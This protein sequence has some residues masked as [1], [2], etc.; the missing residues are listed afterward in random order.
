MHL[1]F[2]GFLWG[3]LGL[4]IPVLIHLL[5]LR[6]PQRV[7][8][9]NTGFIRDIEF[10]TGRRRIQDWI[11]LGLRMMAVV[12]LVSAFCQPYIPARISSLMRGGQQVQV[13]A[14]SSPSMQAPIEG[15]G[16]LE[17]KA[18]AVANILGNSY[19]GN[20]QLKLLGYPGKAVTQGSFRSALAN[21]SQ[22]NRSVGWGAQVV[23]QALEA[24]ASGIVYVV[25]DF[26]KSEVPAK[27]FARLST[28]REVVLVPQAAK[29]AGNAY[30]DSI[31]LNDA[32]VRTK[33]SFDLHIRLR[34]GG[35]E[36][37]TNCPVKVFLDGKQVAALQ[38]TV[39]AGQ[40]SEKVV[41]LQL[42]TEQP[43]TGQVVTA[44]APVAFDNTYYFALQPV[45]AVQVVELG[46]VPVARAAYQ[47]EPL[48]KYNYAPA[49]QADFG[50]LQQANLVLVSGPVAIE[51]GLR[52]ALAGVLQRGG[53]VVVVP[54]ALPQTHEAYR[55]LLQALGVGGVQWET[56]GT[57]Q[58]VLQ[59]LAMPDLRSPFFKDVFGAQPRQVTM[60]EASP[61][62]R[63]AGGGTDILRLR[64]GAGFLTEFEQGPGHVYVFSTPFDKKYSDFTGHA[65]FVP[66]LYRLA[67]LSYRS[68]QP[69][70]YR[71]GQQ[72]VRLR[73][74]VAKTASPDDAAYQLVRDSL[75]FV[76]AQRVL[77]QQ[78]QLQ[79]PSELTKPGLYQL[80]R[81]GKTV[82]TL[83]FNGAK[84]E[85]ELAA[86]SVAEL[87]QLV[88]PNRPN[89]HVLDANEQ[90]AALQNYRAEQ[91]GQPLW[92]YCLLLAL[93]C[94]LAEGAV[95]RWGG[96]KHCA[97]P[98]ARK[99]S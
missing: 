89:V 92:R 61:V 40:A 84:K 80:Q 71:V 3:L 45:A 87:R 38:A 21:Y 77:G 74:P 39:A 18:L 37:I 75:T 31:W 46:P 13:F 12:G 44:D 24:P 93:G 14:D 90:P 59:E 49:Q 25:S 69:L 32:F 63:L 51:T 7:Q 94:L 91:T 48:F 35:S 70:A 36:A 65:L 6:R 76:P 83:A 67:M 23:K 42:A 9:T 50:K 19:K 52:A 41:Q 56:L 11:V 30:V 79:I 33:A 95:L 99:A 73:M 22:G 16:N 64:D 47:N 72:T 58:A 68:D 34:N 2:P 5:H 62:L 15:A 53:S 29:P 1:V 98:A 8:F 96:R 43:T 28:Q 60:P 27:T 54:S 85:S 26:Q 82:A 10:K 4:L 97:Q 55:L 57:N 66:V 81:R 88:G 17:A 86:Y 78:L 20:I